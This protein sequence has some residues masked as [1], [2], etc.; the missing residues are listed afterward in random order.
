MQVEKSYDSP[1]ASWR[2]R[3]DGSTIQCRDEHL[4]IREADSVYIRLRLRT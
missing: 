2:T 4:N 3:E 1:S